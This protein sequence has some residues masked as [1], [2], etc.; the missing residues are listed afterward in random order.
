M[1]VNPGG[2]WYDPGAGPMGDIR[3]FLAGDIKPPQAP[4]GIMRE[5]LPSVVVEA[6]EREEKR[7][8][9]LL[10]RLPEV[11]VTLEGYWIDHGP[12]LDLVHPFVD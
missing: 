4:R 1:T 12:R 9:E 7:W 3:Y 10:A 2:G 6:M 8:A 5:V 11:T